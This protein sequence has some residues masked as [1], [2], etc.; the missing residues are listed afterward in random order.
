MTSRFPISVVCASTALS[1]LA[2]AQSVAWTTRGAADGA[3]FGIAIAGGVDIDVDGVP[4]AL[5]GAPRFHPSFPGTGDASLLS[6]ATG[7]RLITWSGAAKGDQFGAAV[8]IVGD[9]DGD[10]RADLAVGA[11][12]ADVGASN[13]GSVRVLSGATGVPLYTLTGGSG[14]ALFGSSLA[15]LGDVDGDGR[16]DFAVGAP[17]NSVG[18]GFV[19]IV[20]GASGAT[21]RTL[22]GTSTNDRFGVSLS[23]IGDLDLD[24][25]T[26]LMIG[27]ER[28][29]LAA[30]DAGAVLVVSG[31]T[32]A[33]LRTWFGASALDEFGHTI[34]G[35]GDVSGDGVPDALVGAWNDDAGSGSFQPGSVSVISGSSGVVLSRWIGNTGDDHLGKGLASLGDV[36]GDGVPDY[37]YSG[38]HDLNEQHPGNVWVRSGASGDL[39]FF[40]WG[41]RIED[42]LGLGLAR[43]GDVDG[44]GLGDFVVGAPEA[45]HTAPERG[46]A[47]LVLGCRGRVVPVV[48]GCPEGPA[49]PRLFVRGCPGAG[50]MLELSISEAPPLSGARVRIG[51][52]TGLV[53]PS[54]GCAPL[55]AGPLAGNLGVAID[56]RGR[57]STS[58]TVPA[59]LP[60]GTKLA[61][62]ALIRVP[63]ATAVALRTN[64][65]EIQLP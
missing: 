27:A 37:G 58:W 34:A 2:G 35:I 65:V 43:M 3:A 60:S 51:R 29:D 49:Y 1:A 14:G 20:S 40:L 8:A 28:S 33:T 56:G 22:S 9:V 54:F 25:V 48:P 44:D 31:A 55:V 4:D 6:G 63:G 13:S 38:R 64:V 30:S 50:S 53:P 17:R 61:I 45:Y 36:D 47:R 26:D 41:D 52:L 10:G 15:G 16:A 11:P 18:A 62:E 12:R 23:P 24:G 21:L 59:G 32:G 5:V 19:R 57:G 39:L 42:E 7:L 46:Y